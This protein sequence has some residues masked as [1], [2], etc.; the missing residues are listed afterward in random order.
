LNQ[1]G[2]DDENFFHEKRR[3]TFMIVGCDLFKHV[4]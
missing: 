3:V 4:I 1:E 2:F